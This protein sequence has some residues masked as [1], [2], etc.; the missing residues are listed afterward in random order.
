MLYN[1][2]LANSD[3]ILVE[4]ERKKEGEREREVRTE[5]ERDIEITIIKMVSIL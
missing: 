4:G 2:D 5:R 3:P 1:C